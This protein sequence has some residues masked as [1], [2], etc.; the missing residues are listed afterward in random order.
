MEKI[1]I[2]SVLALYAIG[3]MVYYTFRNED[4]ERSYDSGY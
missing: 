4:H 1:I 3:Y 2:L